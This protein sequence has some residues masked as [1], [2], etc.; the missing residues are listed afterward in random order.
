M[1]SPQTESAAK[2][3]AIINKRFCQ[4]TLVTLVYLLP[5]VQAMLPVDDPDIWWHLRTGEWIMRAGW[6][7]T[8]DPF[9]SFGY[10]KPWIAYSWL[11]ELI[12]YGVHSLFGLQGIV[13]FTVVFALLIALALHRLVRAAKLSFRSEIIITAMGLACMKSLMNP[14]P[15][16]F[17]IVF[18]I[19]E[20]NLLLEFKRSGAIRRL[21]WLPV[22][23]FFWA[24]I[25]VQFVYGL[26]V[27]FLVLA[28]PLIVRLVG[29]PGSA[30]PK[31]VGVERGLVVVLALSTLAT[32]ATPYHVFIYRPVF[33]YA[34]QTEVFQNIAELHPLFFRNP[35]DWIFLALMLTASCVLGWRRE[36]GPFPYLLLALGALLSFR[37]RRDVWVGAVAAVAVVSNRHVIRVAADHLEFTAARVMAVALS[38]AIVL[39]GV[40]RLRNITERE[41]QAHVRK[42]FPVDAVAFVR[43][44]NF[45]PPLYNYLDWGGFLI[46]S[47]PQFKVS[48]DGRTNLQ[49]EKRIAANLAVWAGNP[50]WASDAELSGAKLIIAEIGRPLTALLRGDTGFRLVYEDKTSAVFVAAA[51]GEKHN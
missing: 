21:Y 35:V 26:A 6:V 33:E 27:L 32:V 20:L 34:T 29:S 51:N 1:S 38:I 50:G 44:Q 47:L 13:F 16:L 45:A 49:G 18:F 11:F 43:G 7:P 36:T 19:I 25:H 39:L 4:L 8:T 46:W 30:D 14:R 2:G 17:S 40:A 42:T 22:L 28:E 3:L 24:N 5:S 41:L 23:F 10:Q 15:W 31:I 12:L 37:A 9:S 48:M